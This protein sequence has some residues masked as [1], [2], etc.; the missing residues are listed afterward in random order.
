MM[1]LNGPSLRPF[2]KETTSS[3]GIK[4]TSQRE[5]GK[6]HPQGS[7]SHPKIRDSLIMPSNESTRLK[8]ILNDGLEDN[9]PMKPSIAFA[10]GPGDDLDYSMRSWLSNPDDYLQYWLSY[11]G[12]SPHAQSQMVEEPS[13]GSYTRLATNA[14]SEAIERLTCNYDTNFHDRNMQRKD[15]E[16]VSLL[17]RTTALRM[18]LHQ[19]HLSS[20]TEQTLNEIIEKIDQ[21]LLDYDQSKSRQA[22]PGPV[23][24]TSQGVQGSYYGS[25]DSGSGGIQ[26]QRV[27]NQSAGT[28]NR[29]HSG[30]PVV[31]IHDEV[32]RRAIRRLRCFYF[33]G[34]DAAGR[35]CVAMK[36][37]IRDLM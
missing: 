26:N 9:L 16:M 32:E 13:P 35:T 33:F 15:M 30:E 19:V 3:D 25:L 36:K 17:E 23:D 22:S 31:D 29:C 34:P 6:E 18:Q 10:T 7:S 21:L 11:G 24:G 20:N 2:L 8:Y 4:I 27:S 28:S 5:V 1:P 37:N 14:I 12:Q